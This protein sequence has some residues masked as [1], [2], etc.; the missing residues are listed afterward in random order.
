MRGRGYGSIL[1]V[2]AEK[3]LYDKGVEHIY[4]TSDKA[5][6]FWRQCGYK[7][8]GEVSVINHD[9]IFRK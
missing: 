8:T 1:I 3:K 2:N 5:G 9:P 6:G 7:E 4:L